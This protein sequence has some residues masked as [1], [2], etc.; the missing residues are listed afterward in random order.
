MKDYPVTRL[1][2]WTLPLAA[3]FALAG[4]AN[5]HASDVSSNAAWWGEM[6]RGER[7]ALKQ[8]TLL[9]GSVLQLVARKNVRSGY[10]YEKIFG[11]AV[12][13]QMFEANPQGFWNDLYLLPRGT[14]LKC[15]KLERWFSDE[16]PLYLITTEILDGAHKGQIAYLIPYGDPYQKGSLEL[17]PSP[18][19]RP[20]EIAATVEH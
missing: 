2:K 11:D 3:A 8:D 19:V 12:T 7:V 16:G 6:H 9:N 15:V 5:P 14:E 17:G 13:V 18:L 1:L 20:L 4:C 10:H